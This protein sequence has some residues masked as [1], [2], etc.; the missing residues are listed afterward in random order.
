MSKQKKRHKSQSGALPWWGSAL[1]AVLLAVVV[2]LL[3]LWCQ[4]NALRQIAGI[5][6]KHGVRSLR[7]VH[8]SLWLMISVWLSFTV[9]TYNPHADTLW[10]IASIVSGIACALSF[11]ELLKVQNLLSTH[12]MPQFDREDKGGG[13]NA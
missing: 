1:L 12:P 7:T 4:P 8:G 9:R 3:A 10:Y 13:A 6:V 2:T 11:L 5:F